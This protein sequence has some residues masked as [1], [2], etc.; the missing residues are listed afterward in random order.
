MNSLKAYP[1][2]TLRI[3]KVDTGLQKNEKKYEEFATRLGRPQDK[4]RKTSPYL[5]NDI[6]D[7]LIHS[8]TWSVGER[9][10]SLRK[11][12]GPECLRESFFI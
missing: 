3:H 6:V 12:L 4:K 10:F 1:S 2:Y 9:A 7:L 11:I 5:S 8:R